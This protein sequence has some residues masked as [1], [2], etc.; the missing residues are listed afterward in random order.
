MSTPAVRE[1]TPTIVDRLAREQPDKIYL[2]VAK[3]AR[4]VEYEDIN[5][6]SFARAV[7]RCAWWIQDR[8][9][10]TKDVRPIFAMLPPQDIR[11]GVLVL[12]AVKTG[13]VV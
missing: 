3:D 7:N 2:S 10:D 6:R 1:L 8:I 12:A 9:G 4:G 11:H 13:N 5:F